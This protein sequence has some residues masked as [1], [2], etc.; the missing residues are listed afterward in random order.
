MRGGD[1]DIS[2]RFAVYINDDDDD[3]NDNADDNNNFKDNDNA[4]DNIDDD[5]DNGN[6][7]NNDDNDSDMI[8][9]VIVVRS[10]SESCQALVATPV[11]AGAQVASGTPISAQCTH[12]VQSLQQI[13]SLHYLY[14]HIIIISSIIF[15][16][17]VIVIVVFIVIVDVDV[18]VVVNDYSYAVQFPQQIQPPLQYIVPMSL[19]I[20]CLLGQFCRARIVRAS[21]GFSK[22]SF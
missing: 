7:D 8:I 16:L 18:D 11:P 19:C 6:D 5:N 4:N 3:A 2:R 22:I 20:P 10:Q 13:Q 9:S 1:W 21:K 14:H 12:A 17:I 15:I